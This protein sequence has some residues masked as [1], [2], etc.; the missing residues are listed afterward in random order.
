MILFLTPTSLEYTAVKKAL[1][2]S[3]PLRQCGVGEQQAGLFCQSL[4]ELPTCLVLIGWAGGLTPD[5]TV[6]EIICAD[7]ALREGQPP[8]PCSPLPLPGVHTGPVLTVPQALLTPIEK[9]RAHQASGALAVEMEA[10]PIAAWAHQH[11]IPFIHLRVISDRWDESLP[12][13]G[14]GLDR[15]GRVHFLPLLQQLVVHP[16]LIR[17]LWHLNQRIQSLNP[18]LGTLASNAAFILKSE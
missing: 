4:P 16:T 10:Y 7:L 12:D 1:P 13:L 18:I 15:S 6:G 11:N 8:L 5:L 3:I 17:S 9:S 14:N 2:D